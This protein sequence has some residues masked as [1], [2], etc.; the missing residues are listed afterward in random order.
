MKHIISICLLMVFGYIL[1]AQENTLTPAFKKETIS[2]LSKMMNDFYVFPEVAKK[3]G[4]HL[5]KKLKS[6]DF[7][8]FTT[9]ES[10]AKALTTETQSIN[11]DKH[12]RIRAIRPTQAKDNSV[13]KMFEDHINRLNYDRKNPG[14]FNEAKKLEGNVGYFDIRSFAPLEVGRDYA[15]SYMKLLSSSDAIIVDLRKNGGG[16]PAMV[17]Y[18][19]SYFFGKKTHLNSLYY[20]EG[21]KTYEFWTL[22][23]VNGQKMPDVPL[24]VLT[25]DRTFSGAEEFS[26]NMQTQKRATLVGQTTGG[27]ANPGRTMRVNDKIEV[28]IP[29]GTAINPITKT[30]WE[31]VGVIPAIKTSIDETFAKA[32]EL[33][34]VAAENYRNQVKQEQTDLSTALIKTLN[35]FDEKTREQ[36]IYD[37]IKKCIEAGFLEEWSVNIMGYEYLMSYNK[38]KVAEA[39]LKTNTML[40]PE[41][42]NVY[43]SYG[44]AL[45]INGKL[46]KALV[47][48]Q[49]AVDIGKKTN[50][51]DLNVFMDNVKKMEAQMK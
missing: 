41:S 6:G 48:F 30:N 26:Y 22:D 1:Q 7:D 5:N 47:S 39:I 19:C 17:Q 46:K 40:F 34:K 12:M 3:T 4:E 24:F 28:F 43:D 37:D 9:L 44:D 16:D 50:H 10:F 35:N 25:S 38:P 15:D 27:G 23:E 42:A 31:G 2:Q 20:R 33:A 21:D 29:V 49:Q 51:R 14:G 18:L 45:S 11:K 13:E 36:T 32:H 8:S